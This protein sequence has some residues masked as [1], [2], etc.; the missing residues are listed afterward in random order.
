MALMLWS[1]NQ[2]GKAVRKQLGGWGWW[3]VGSTPVELSAYYNGEQTDP[4]VQPD[5]M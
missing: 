2:A 4:D 3:A 1:C 5:V